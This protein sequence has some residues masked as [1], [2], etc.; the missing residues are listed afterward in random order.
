[1]NHAMRILGVFFHPSSRI[2][3]LY[4]PE[5]TILCPLCQNTSH[6]HFY[7]TQLEK[8][9]MQKTHTW[10][11]IELVFK[12]EKHYGN[13]YTDVDFWVDLHGPG[14]QKRCY[15]FWDGGQ[16]HIVRVLAPCPGVWQWTSESSTNDPGLS[17]H[18]GQFKAL[19]WSED[20]KNAN[21]TRRGMI[22]ATPNGHAFQY[23]D[24]TPF[25]LLGD[26]WWATPTYR[27]PWHEDADQQPLGPKAG[28]K[29]YVHYRKQ[30]GYNCIA[31]I[32]S[33]ANWQNDDHPPQWILDDGLVVRSAWPQAGTQ[34]AEAMHNEHGERAFFFPG[35]IKGLETY[36]P[37]LESINP[38]YFQMMDQKI[39]YLNQQGFVPF[40]EAA[41]RDIGQLWQ[42]YYPWPDSYARYV[43]YVWSRYQ[44]NI[45]LFSPIHY[46]WSGY[47]IPAEV[48]NDATMTVIHNYGYPPFGTLLGTNANPS[49][50]ENWGH[51]DKAP[52]LGFHQIGNQ[53]T[54]DVYHHLTDIFKAEPP[55][56][57]ING[58]PYY[59]GMEDAEPGSDKAARYCRSAIY[60]S[61]LSGGLGG[62]IYG[63]G[64]WK[65]GIWSGEVEEE[66]LDPIW[67]AIQ[68][69]SAAHMP[70][71][72]DFI[73]S[74]G[75]VYQSLMPATESL[76]PNRSGDPKSN[77]SWAFCAKT[78]DNH[79][80]FCYF[81]K[82]CPQAILMNLLPDIEYTGFW[83]DP[84]QGQWLPHSFEITT[85][86]NGEVLLPLFPD[87][88]KSAN[89]D[90]ALKLKIVAAPAT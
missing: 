20:E 6:T 4:L 86:T 47:S 49:S 80:V 26:T 42:R 40:I 65:G 46:D 73:L 45:C 27:F 83:F 71:C 38:A 2:R 23:A 17:G 74:E 85:D 39:D 69:E 90:W 1:M 11:K 18:T 60:G 7:N 22:Q 57:G 59:D 70:Y 52:W 30:Q 48:W 28:F 51:L 41:R 76:L 35:R 78:S 8:Q 81:E 9:Q 63:A 14:F 64:G 75:D 62:H 16:K 44:A 61:V 10:Q 24:G 33:F 53:R 82:S 66:S 54:H 36:V 88:W 13:P 31:M 12:A 56:P 87:G 19:A 72:R 67:K 5:D 50:L 89:V 79:L 68:W 77:E 29:D 25:F 32:A 15:G 37:D 3:H 55:I 84:R 43:H 21:P 34:S 58:E